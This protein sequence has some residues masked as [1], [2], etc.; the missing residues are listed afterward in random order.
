MFKLLLRGP[1]RVRER[2]CSIVLRFEL[3]VLV[4]DEV[5]RV[6]TGKGAVEVAG[7]W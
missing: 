7:W 5:R 1:V 6:E 3:D 2:S 4:V